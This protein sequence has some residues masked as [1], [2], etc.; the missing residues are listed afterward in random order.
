MCLQS[1][2]QHVFGLGHGAFIGIN[3]KQYAVNHVQHAFYLATE[4][5]MARG[6]QNVDFYAIMH[7]SSI[8]GQ[9]SD[10][11]FTLQIVGVH[12]ALFHMLVRTE[13][14]ALLQHRIDQGGLAMVNVGNNGYITNI[15]SN[16]GPILSSLQSYQININKKKDACQVHPFMISLEY[17]ML[18]MVHCQ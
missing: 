6:I 17:Y 9:N 2:A 12:N 10:T 5:S 18:L 7:N 8:F 15:V 13:N 14:A 11:T 3:Q 16:H 4:V 1:L